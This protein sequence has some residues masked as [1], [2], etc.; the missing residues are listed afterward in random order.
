[1]RMSGVPAEVEDSLEE[2]RRLKPLARKEGCY[3]VQGDLVVAA[4]GCAVKV[5]SKSGEGW[6]SRELRR[7][8]GRRA[9]ELLAGYLAASCTTC[10]WTLLAPMWPALGRM[11]LPWMLWR[12][13]VLGR[14]P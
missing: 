9:L 10:P 2:D 11:A 12:M 3:V 6:S 1:M 7:L 5:F 14:A 4:L 13:A 8:M